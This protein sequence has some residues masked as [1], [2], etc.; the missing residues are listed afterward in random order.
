MKNFIGKIENPIDK[1]KQLNGYYF[2]GNDKAIE[3]GFDDTNIQIGVSAQEVESVLP[4]LIQEAPI[5]AGHDDHD[6]KTLNYGKLTPLL[7]EAIKELNSKVDALTEEIKIL[8]GD[9]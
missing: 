6:Y 5:S 1:I 3:L 9:K 7:I 2:Y 8:K 4:E